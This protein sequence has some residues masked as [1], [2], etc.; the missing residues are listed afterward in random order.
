MKAEDIQLGKNLEKKV[1]LGLVV[2][3][4]ENNYEAKDLNTNTN[5]AKVK[6]KNNNFAL[7]ES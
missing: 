5:T 3:F 4:H 6:T 7:A 1:E 2:I